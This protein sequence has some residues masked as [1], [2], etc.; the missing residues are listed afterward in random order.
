MI[1]GL[2]ALVIDRPHVNAAL[3]AHGVQFVNENDARRLGFGLLEQVADASRAHAH[4]HLHKIAAA[5]QK[6]RDLGFAGHG[7]RQKGFAGSG[8]ADQ[9]DA[10]GNRRAQRFVAVRVFQE[11]HHFLQF[12]LGLIA[13]RHVVESHPGILVRHHFGSA[14]AEAH[15]ALPNASHP[16]RQEAPEQHHRGDRQDPGPDNLRHETRANPRELDTRLLEIA[17][18]V[19]VLHANRA[20]HIG[21][22]LRSFALLLAGFRQRRDS[23]CHGRDLGLCGG[24]RTFGGFGR[25]RGQRVGFRRSGWMGLSLRC[26]FRQDFAGYFRLI[27]RQV[28]DAA[29]SHQLFELAVRN[30]SGRDVVGGLLPKPQ[31][32]QHEQEST[33]TSSP[34]AGVATLGNCA[35]DREGAGADSFAAQRAA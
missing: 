21:F 16:A 31:H 34:T 17:N 11:R 18:E 8:R 9:Q 7:P 24:V 1:Q 4:E 26:W 20:K 19:R 5:D 14:R 30:C 28:R 6:E 22:R 35:R 2:L 32:S 33:I 15:D 29:F 27:D 10:L 12:V 23:I 13:A 25:P 3:A